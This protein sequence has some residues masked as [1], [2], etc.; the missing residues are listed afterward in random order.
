MFTAPAMECIGP[1]WIG[2]RSST[3]ACANCACAQSQAPRHSPARGIALWSWRRGAP[4]DREF[5]PGEDVRSS[6]STIIRRSKSTLFTMACRWKFSPARKRAQQSRAALGL[7]E[8][9][10]AVL[11]AGSGWERKGLRFAIEAVDACADPRCGSSSRDSGN[12]R[13][14]P[15]SRGAASSASSADLPAALRGGRY[16]S[17]ADNLRSVSRMP[18]SR[19]WRPACRSSRPAPT[20]SPR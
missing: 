18:A 4:R 2:G 5:P 17:S 9:D 15:I 14:Y 1:G 6:G 10:I 3:A 13:R 16:F 12:E 8:D 11:F 7:A 20:V 19:R